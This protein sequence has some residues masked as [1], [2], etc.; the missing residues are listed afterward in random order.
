[1]YKIGLTGGIASGKSMVLKWFKA[2]GVKYIDADKVARK[3]VEPES[4]GLNEIVTAFGTDILLADGN[5]D[6]AKMA[7][8]IFKNEEKRLLLNSIIH[9]YIRAEIKREEEALT[10]EGVKAII[11]DIPLLI[12]S[13]WYEQMDEVW[14]VYANMDVRIERLMHRDN[15]DAEYARNKIASQ[16]DLDEKR[17]YA[18]IIIENSGTVKKLRLR[19]QKIWANKKSLF[20]EVN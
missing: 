17:K 3:V 16:M 12:E 6:R 18:D 1:M 9:K 2:K 11:Y 8:I 13:K 19:L 15:I 7:S 5:L 20:G 4:A 10:V 14:L